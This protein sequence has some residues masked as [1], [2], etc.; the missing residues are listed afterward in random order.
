MKLVGQPKIILSDKEKNTL[1]DAADILKKIVDALEN[2]KEQ[3][4]TSF[5][6]GLDAPMSFWD[7]C[8]NVHRIDDEELIP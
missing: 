5:Q 8:R 4:F 6:E 1:Y 3:G 7:I 2:N